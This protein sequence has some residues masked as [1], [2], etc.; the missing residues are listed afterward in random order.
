L[1]QEKLCDPTAVDGK[2]EE[3]PE[4]DSGDGIEW[5]K[6]L[7]WD[8]L[9][10]YSEWDDREGQKRC[11]VKFPDGWK[12]AVIQL[13]YC[14]VW[15]EVSDKYALVYLNNGEMQIGTLASIR[16]PKETVTLDRRLGA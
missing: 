3:V 14:P 1:E 6:P 13:V 16:I 11:L 12:K 2:L 8:A 7:S 9:E 5:V 15:A 4:P 10:V